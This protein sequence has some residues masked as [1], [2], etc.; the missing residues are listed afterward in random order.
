MISRSSSSS[1]RKS[2]LLLSALVWSDKARAVHLIELTVQSEEG[3][4]AAFER[5]KTKYSELAAECREAGWKATIYPVEVGYR[6]YLGHSATRF[7]REAGVTRG[8]LREATKN[9]AEEAEKGSFWLGLRR[10]D[11]SWGKNI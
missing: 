4:E 9:L 7:L 1:P 6:G 10:K 2:Q 5:K 8:K 3:I 11:R